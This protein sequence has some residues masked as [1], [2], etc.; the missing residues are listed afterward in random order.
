MIVLFSTA[1][2]TLNN[3][4]A[5]EKTVRKQTFPLAMSLTN[6]SWAFPFKQVFRFNPIYP[7]ISAETEFYYKSKPTFKLFQTGQI[8]GFL[9]N[10]SGSAIYLNSNIGMR[11]ASKFGLTTELS[12][13]LGYFFGLYSSD[14]YIQSANG[15]YEKSKKAGIGAMSGNIS[16]GFGYD[17]SIKFDKNITP[18]LRYQWIASTYYWSL[19]TIR[20]NGLLHLGARFYPFK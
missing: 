11:Y 12:L 13:G 10:S 2:L 5:Q 3:S 16:I 6:H 9:N 14:T 4:H 17:F 8:G 15:N 20:P 7:G 19:I 1:I 18:F